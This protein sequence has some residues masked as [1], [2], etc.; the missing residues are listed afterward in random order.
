MSTIPT[1]ILGLVIL[2]LLGKFYILPL[3]FS[4]LSGLQINRLS[5]LSLRGLEYRIGDDA[6]SVI[7]TLRLERAAWA[8]GGWK[9]DGV[10]G[11]IVLRLEG[12]SFRVK[13]RPKKDK[14]K[15]VEPR[16]KV[17]TDSGRC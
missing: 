15:P 14:P 12:V 13:K 4:H 2:S 10:K 5:F 6:H 1:V 7:P 17:S 9:E 11:L 3:L 8:W 16:P